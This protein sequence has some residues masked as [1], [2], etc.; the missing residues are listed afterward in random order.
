MIP[1]AILSLARIEIA[2][3]VSL[4]RQ[5]HD[6]LGVFNGSAFNPANI[7]V[8]IEGE[9]SLSKLRQAVLI[10]LNSHPGCSV[11]V[12]RSRPFMRRPPEK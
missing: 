1:L 10:V 3:I 2:Y 5:T 6:S 12:W 7:E 4:S 11:V 8:K 9:D